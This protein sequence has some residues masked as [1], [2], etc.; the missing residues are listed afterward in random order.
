VATEEIPD[1][2]SDLTV[3]GGRTVFSTG[4]VTE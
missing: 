1:I 3:V 4:A 2:G